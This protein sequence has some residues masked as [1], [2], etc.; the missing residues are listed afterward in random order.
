MTPSSD[1]QGREVAADSGRAPEARIAVPAI[2][3]DARPWKAFFWIW[4]AIAS[5]VMMA[6]SGREIQEE[7]NTFQLMAWRSAVGFVI[8]LVL[9]SWSRRGFGQVRPAR[10][11]LHVWRNLF[12][13]TGQNAWFFALTLIPLSQLV[14]LE[15]S[16]PVWVALLAPLVLGE[17]MTR[18]KLIAVAMGFAGVLI[19][20]QPGVQPLNIGH[21]A[22][23]VAALGFALNTLWTK[24]IMSY[25][26]VLCV[27]F[28][29]TLS[30]MVMGLAL[31]LPGG[32]P[33][34]ST[35]L[36]PWLLV[37]GVTGLTAHFSLTTALS[38]AP[39]SIVAPMEF[40]R[41]P[42]IAMVGMVLYAEP[43][44]LA[45]FLGGGVILIANLVNMGVG[46][47]QRWR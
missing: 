31:G 8:V 39:A 20:A 28:W 46:S 29:M 6:V 43:L 27:L 36:L 44:M 33:W 10:P 47:T 34:P 24:K 21:A 3:A 22:A 40:L 13:F 11:M 23:L 14:A 17:S 5:F 45:V 25:D 42:V 1:P 7:M 35:G 15:F 4:G 30:Q 2:P 9:V 18:R 32:F 26:T 16:N 41:L 19:V 38:H 12:H 37:V